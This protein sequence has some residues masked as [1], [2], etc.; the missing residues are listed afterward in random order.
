[1]HFGAPS[2]TCERSGGCASPNEAPCTAIQ[3]VYQ[4]GA[5]DNTQ[6]LEE[7]DACG[8][9]FIAS[10]KGERTHKTVKDIFDR[11]WPL[12]GAPRRMLGRQ[13]PGDVSA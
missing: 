11:D 6:L 9:G 2:G 7:H 4:G 1:M 3:P 10:L 13:R 8:V 12:H 5:V